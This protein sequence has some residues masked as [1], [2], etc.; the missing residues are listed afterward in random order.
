MRFSISQR[1]SI[2]TETGVEERRL[3][4]D[5]DDQMCTVSGDPKTLE[6]LTIALKEFEEE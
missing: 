5:C 1:E 6:Q 4:I 2:I 3:E